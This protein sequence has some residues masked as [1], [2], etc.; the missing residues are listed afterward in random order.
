MPSMEDTLMIDPPPAAF[1]GSARGLHAQERSG[2]VDV[3]DLLPLG[4]VELPDLA[5]RDDARVV[6]QDVE[7]TEV[8]DGRRHGGVPLVGL[9][10]VEVT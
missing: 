8:L 4:H 10:D 7:Q 6:H 5:E 9:G 3:D 2:E 1:I